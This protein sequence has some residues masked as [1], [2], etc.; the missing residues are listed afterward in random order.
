M[1][2][3]DSLQCNERLITNNVESKHMITCLEEGE[4]VIAELNLNQTEK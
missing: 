4:K 1:T 2:M 3:T